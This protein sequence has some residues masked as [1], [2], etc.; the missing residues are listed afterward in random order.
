M[1]TE[2]ELVAPRGYCAGV[3]RAIQTVER[4]LEEIG[5]PVYVR[6]EIVHN[7]HVVS[8]LRAKGAIFVERASEVPEGET[9]ILSAHG[10]SPEVHRVCR[11]RGL[12]VID[13]T[14]PLVSK[15]HAEVRRYAGRGATVLLVGHADHEEVVGTRGEAPDAVIVVEDVAGAETVEVPDPE[16]VALTTQTTLSIDDTAAIVDVLKR[17]FPALAGPKSSDICY[18][19]QNRQDAVRAVVGD[20]ADLVL[21]VGS[22]NSSNS[23]R[24]VEVARSS[25]AA[26]Y[27]IDNVGELDPTWLEGTRRVALTA[28]ASAPEVLVQEVASALV[29]SGYLRGGEELP[30]AEG[31][32]FRLPVEVRTTS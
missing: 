11:E 22:R 30:S 29:A 17:R 19:T 8:T 2:L 12:R 18:A 20:G 27:L 4:V 13:A 25:G 10:V 23:N 5:A 16:R 26:S 14:C 28:G 3:E 6:G 32:F 7:T 9:I 15:V 24:M 1:S 31:V 21:V